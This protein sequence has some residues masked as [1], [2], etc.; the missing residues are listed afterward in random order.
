MGIVMRLLVAG[1]M[2]GTL[3]GLVAVTL[4][5]MLRSTGIL[6]FA[7]AGFALVAAYVYNDQVC[8]Q[9]PT[10]A[11]PCAAARLSPGQASVL[12]VLVAVVC[13]LLVE[14]FIARPLAQASAAIK[15]IATAA[16]LGLMTG[17]LLQIY[18]AQPRATPP[19]NASLSVPPTLLLAYLSYLLL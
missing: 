11:R 9:D 19:T 12:A 2:I 17:L 5:L 3:Y 13:A 14:R 1:V 7:H 18:G 15:M 16:A 6:S 8:P 10:F 4:T